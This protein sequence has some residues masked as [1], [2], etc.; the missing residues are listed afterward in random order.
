MRSLHIVYPICVVIAAIIITMATTNTG[1]RYFALMIMVPG[2]YGC[3]QVSNAWVAS[4]AARPKQKRAIAL[5]MS[6][7]VG[8]TSLIWTPYL[9]PSS[10][11]PRYTVAWSVNIALSVVC[12]LVSLWLRVVLQRENKRMESMESEA[13]LG[14]TQLKAEGKPVEVEYAGALPSSA[15]Q[16]QC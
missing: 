1:A 9:Y 6:N 3:F 4:V 15:F 16:F 10:A 12:I 8:N 5:A 14:G 11:G 2:S 7:A 13:D